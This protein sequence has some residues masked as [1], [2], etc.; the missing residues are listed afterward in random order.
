M[1]FATK[2]S[3]GCIA[4]LSCALGAA[5]LLLTGQSFSGSLASTR[6]AMQAQQEKEKYALERIIFQA[7]DSAQFENYILASAAQQYAEQTA[8]A[9]SSMALWLDGAYALYSGLPAALPRTA[10]KQALTDGEN[11]WQLTRAAGRWYL[12]LTQPLDLPGVRA[13]MLCA[14]DVSAVFATRDAQLRAWLAASAG[15]PGVGGIGGAA[16]IGRRCGSAVQPPCDP[17]ADCA[18][19]GQREN[20]RWGVHPAHAGQD[21]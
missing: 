6:T 17:P 20:C 2:L 19:D 8:D 21:R 3:L 7:T 18:A 5:G 12:L 15:G 14:Y 11:A 13:D 10:L 4:L 9:G 16:G 1:K